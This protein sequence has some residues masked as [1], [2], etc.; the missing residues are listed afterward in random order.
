MLTSGMSMPPVP[1][2]KSR[3]VT[4]NSGLKL[5]I[6]RIPLMVAVNSELET[7]IAIGGAPSILTGLKFARYNG[8]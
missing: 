4:A 5:G 2:L 7:E 1:T 8:N 6:L 3:I